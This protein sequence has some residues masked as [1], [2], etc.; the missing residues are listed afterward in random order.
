M[1]RFKRGP[2]AFKIDYAL[3]QP[4]P[5]RASECRRAISLHLGGTLE[6]IAES[7]DL[8]NMGQHP[9]RPFVLVAQPS[10]FDHTRALPGR[11]RCGPTATCPTDPR[12]I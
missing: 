10:L 3:S 2:G 7:E 8:V 5:W 1:E 9:E 11:T 12:S 4:V 6:E